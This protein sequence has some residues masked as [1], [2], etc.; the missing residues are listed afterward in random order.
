MSVRI[1][2]SL[3][4]LACCEALASRRYDEAYNQNDEWYTATQGES[5]R[6]RCP[7]YLALKT[8]VIMLRRA[9]EIE[10]EEDYYVSDVWDIFR[11]VC[12]H[13][14]FDSGAW[15]SRDANLEHPTPFAYLI[16]EILLDLRELCQ[17]TR[18]R[19]GSIRAPG[20]LGNDLIKTWASCAAYLGYSE[21][22]VSDRFLFECLGYY[23]DYVL[24]IKEDYETT[25]DEA[26]ENHGLWCAQFVEELLKHEAGEEKL[27]GFLIQAMQQLDVGKI[28]VLNHKDWLKNELGL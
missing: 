16:K 20:R 6:L 28:Y 23:L 24:Q 22:R 1:D 26:K 9:I 5:T 2:Y 11:D 12:K 3:T 13:S 10:G 14:K 19:G 4:V 15:E 27:K 18:M 7:I 25:K 21:D 8:H 17:E